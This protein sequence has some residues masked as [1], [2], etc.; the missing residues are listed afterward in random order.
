[1]KI[2]TAKEIQQMETD[3][4]HQANINSLELMEMASISFVNW[5]VQAFPSPCT[6]IVCCGPGKNGGDG[7]VISR[8]LHRHAYTVEV[9]FLAGSKYAEEFT[10]NKEK[11]QQLIPVKEIHSVEDFPELNK[12]SIVLDALFGIGINKPLAGPA[13]ELVH[14]INRSKATIISIDIASG[15]LPA[16]LT[17]GGAIV[18]PTVTVTFQVPKLSFMLPQ[19]FKNVGELVLLDIGIPQEIQHAIPSN[20]LFADKETILPW[21]KKRSKIAHKGT[22]GKAL[23]IGG[24]YGMIGAALLAA[25]AGYCTGAGLLRMYIPACGYTIAQTALPEAMVL[26]DP[27]FTE[28]TTIPDLQPY[29]AIAIGP[30][31]KESDGGKDALVALLKQAKFPLVIDAGALNILGENRELMA[32]IPPNSILTP[33]PKEFERL[34][35]AFPNDFERLKGLQSFSKQISSIVI[36]KG[37]NTAIALPNG[38]VYFNSTGNPGMATGG[39][40]DVL[41]GIITGLLAQTYTAEQAAVLGVFLHGYAGDSAAEKYSQEAMLASNIIEGIAAFYKEMMK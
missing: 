36:L 5:F 33:H 16:D 12:A 22:Y 2:L 39:S 19:Y 3:Y 41:C 20:Y 34:T 14:Y 26:T 30:G 23:V 13:A 6:V 24:S 31:M 28:I 37:A 32:L 8:L 11:L 17:E 10:S 21:L 35:K 29:N 18:E 27:S 40:G 25:K 1:M 7:L 15:L 38:Q 9:Y 4:M